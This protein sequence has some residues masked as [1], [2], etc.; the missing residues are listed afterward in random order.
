MRIC[1]ICGLIKESENCKD[2][3]GEE[4]ELPFDEEL[5]FEDSDDED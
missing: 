4:K 5:Y 1:L 3:L 2:C